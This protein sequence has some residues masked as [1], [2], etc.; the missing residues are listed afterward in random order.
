MQAALRIRLPTGACSTSASCSGVRAAA[1]VQIQ[2]FAA[3]QYRQFGAGAGVGG[4]Y[5][6]SIF[7]GNRDTEAGVKQV[8]LEQE[9]YDPW[10]RK[11][12]Y[13]KWPGIVSKLGG[14]Y[15]FRET[16]QPVQFF[17]M[18]TENDK[19]GDTCFVG[20]TDARYC[21]AR[22]IESCLYENTRGFAIQLVLYGRG[23]KAYF[24]PS[25]PNLMIRLGVGVKVIDATRIAKRYPGDVRVSVSA[26]GDLMTVHGFDKHKVAVVAHRLF[27]T[28]QANPYTMKGGHIAGHPIKQKH[29]KK[30]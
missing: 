28:I 13:M 25:F 9:P 6:A 29:T 19:V 2:G 3:Q 20:S 7:G 8:H 4:S 23:V 14:E 17:H 18:K 30:K 24:E 22:T 12:N 5:G 27:N 10:P 15:Y 21:E 1:A 11:V 26:K 16:N